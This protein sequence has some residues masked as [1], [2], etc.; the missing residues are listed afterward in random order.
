MLEHGYMD[1][2]RMQ[3]TKVVK[4][5]ASQV[6]QIYRLIYNTRILYGSVYFKIIV[7]LL[8]YMFYS[9]F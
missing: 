2:Y 5:T 6:L 1:N 4:L 9:L 3:A 8:A 7:N